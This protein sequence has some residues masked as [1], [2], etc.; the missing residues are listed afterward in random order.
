MPGVGRH[1][2]NWLNDSTRTDLGFFVIDP[3]GYVR[4]CNHSPQRP[5][6]VSEIHK[7]KTHPYWRRS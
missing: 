3:S 7:V 4:T 2:A 5:N 6:D 1:R